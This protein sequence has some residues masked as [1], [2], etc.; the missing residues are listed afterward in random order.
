MNLEQELAGLRSDRVIDVTSAVTLATG[1]A[2]GY[3]TYDSP[4]G[5]VVVAFNIVGISAVR[6]EEEGQERLQATIGR[7]LV[8]SVPP[9]GWDRMIGR[10]IEMGRPGE[11]PL[12]LRSVGPF[13]RSIL[14]I[15]ATIPKGEVRPYGWLANEAGNPRAVR[16]VGTAM[17]RNPVPLI[18]PCHRVIR[19]DGTIGNYSLGGRHNKVILLEREGHDLG[20]D[21][22][23]PVNLNHQSAGPRRTLQPRSE[24]GSGR[25]NRQT[26]R[27]T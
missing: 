12:D 18:V 6:L 22:D 24:T 4:V 25:R 13:Q 5:T 19:S 16:A 27:T 7:P 20:A 10:A 2:D 11:L 26:G 14:Q 23:L 3:R 17:A 1:L 21:H 9:Q 8:E 15:A